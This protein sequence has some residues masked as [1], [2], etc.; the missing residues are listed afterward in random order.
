MGVYFMLACAGLLLV[1]GAIVLPVLVYSNS[2]T[3]TSLAPVSG[4]YAPVKSSERGQGEIVLLRENSEIADLRDQI[5]DK[6][7][8][9]RTTEEE[10][11]SINTQLNQIYKKKD[12]LE[13]KLNGLTLTKRR[14]EAQIRKTEDSIQQGQL[15]LKTLNTSIGD[16]AENLEVL[17]SVLRRNFQQA[18]EFELHG[19]TLILMH[20]SFSDVLQRIEEIERYSKALHTHLKF[21]EDETKE[22][23]QNKK[24]V[25]AERTTL[26][27]QQKEL[28]DRKKI[29]EFSIAQQELLVKKTRNDEAV[30]QELLQGKQEERLQITTGHLRI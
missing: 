28:A 4:N 11:R 2:A 6:E 25:V 29:Y 24:D 20:T 5:G 1:V 21:L 27:R 12:S 7:S 3:I 18:N 16:N 10:I 23:H 22:L 13:S 30:Y 26:E 9:I 8:R 15:K 19:K 14:N 17:Y